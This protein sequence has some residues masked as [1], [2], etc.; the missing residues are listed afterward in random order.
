MNYNANFVI[1]ALD[2][3]AAL[4]EIYTVAGFFLN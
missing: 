2:Q 3:A 4:Q 1:F